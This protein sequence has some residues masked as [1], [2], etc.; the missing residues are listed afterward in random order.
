MPVPSCIMVACIPWCCGKETENVA[1]QTEVTKAPEHPKVLQV[2]RGT[3][4]TE[5]HKRSIDKVKKD[6][7][8]ALP[9]Q[10]G[11][12]PNW[13]VAYSPPHKAT[14]FWNQ[15]THETTWEWPTMDLTPLDKKPGSKTDL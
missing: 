15:T 4:K 3:K 11:L 10:L 8:Y 13:R 6:S 9:A 5:I 14:Y 7:C 2:P 12:P 1:T